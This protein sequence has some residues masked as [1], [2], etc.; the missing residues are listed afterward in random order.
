MSRLSGPSAFNMGNEGVI[1]L[2]GSEGENLKIL[3]SS[4]TLHVFQVWEKSSVQ[5]M[6]P[7][8]YQELKNTLISC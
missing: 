8:V 7:A 4:L 6:Y 3:P 2:I 5:D 1:C